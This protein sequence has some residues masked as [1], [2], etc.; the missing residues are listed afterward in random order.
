M[1]VVERVIGREVNFEAHRDLI[2]E[3]IEALRADTS[4][5]PA[6]NAEARQ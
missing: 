6:A 4:G 3:A 5:G 1:D 2:D